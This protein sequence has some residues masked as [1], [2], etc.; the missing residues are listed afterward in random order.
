MR[1]VVVTGI[2]LITPL[3]NDTASTW[4]G[5]LAGRSGI[6][7]ITSFDVSAYEYSIAGELKGFEPEAHVDAKLL[8]RIDRSSVLAM[9]ASK[10]A[11]ADAGLDIAN[12]PPGA[13]GV[14]LGTGIGG[15]H[16]IVE[17]QQLLD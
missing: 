12:E 4:D 1:R 10:Q 8:R 5:L 14:V 2:G 13:V 16:L 7:R 6:G 9:A 3:G 11:V 17:N 15:A